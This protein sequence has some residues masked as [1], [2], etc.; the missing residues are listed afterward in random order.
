MITIGTARA[1]ADLSRGLFLATVEV[2]ATP[3]RVFEALTS[4]DIL[5]WW[6]R[7]GIFDT[8]EWSGDIRTGGEWRASGL[9][10]GNPYVLQGEFLD[11]D[12]PRRLVHT[13][14]GAGAPGGPT[15]VIY[16]LEAVEGG[17]RITLRHE[18]FEQRATCAATCIGWETSFEALAKLL[19]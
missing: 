3:D 2:G 8:R 12:P 5:Q 14:Q 7:P 16:E 11:V 17:T 13:W 4:A 9:G 6:V 1:A 18:G 10:R 15:T 19:G